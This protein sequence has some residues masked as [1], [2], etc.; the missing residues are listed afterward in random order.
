MKRLLVL[1]AT[2]LFVPTS[3]ASASTGPYAP[4]N[5]PGPRLSVPVADL[6]AA[7]RC[8]PSAYGSH[9]EVA[10]FVP[11]TGVGPDEAFSWNWFPAL[12]RIGHPYCSVTLP[13]G[14]VGD[15]QV[16]AEY[17][18]HA[19]RYARAISRGKIAVIG[20]SQGGVSSRFA[21]RFWPDTRAMVADHVGLAAV[22][23]G[24]VQND[25]LYPHGNG[26]AFALQLKRTAEF[27][28]ATNSRQETFAGISYTSLSTTHDQFVTLAGTTDLRG[29]AGRVAN[30]SLQDVCPDNPS[31]HITIG[32]SDALAYALTVNAIT[33]RG[34]ANPAEIPASVCAQENMPGVDPSTVGD[35]L[36]GFLETALD[37]IAAAPVTPAEPALK[38]YVFARR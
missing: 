24:S 34:P 23:H 4:V 7:V 21:L 35:D 2:L 38:P 27:V 11:G 36:A 18:V 25:D 3:V 30:I 26:P 6:Q 29:P 33:R 22:N 28:E 13:G 10:L 15:V 20:H 12:D 1:V 16:S 8:T 5:Q 37:V 19:I 9:R 14:S 17:V 32:T 31:D